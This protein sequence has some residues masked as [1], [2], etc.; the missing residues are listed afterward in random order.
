MPRR[1]PAPPADAPLLAWLLHILA[2][3]SRTRVKELLR[4]G[5]VAVNGV[6]VTRH[7]HPV[8]PADTLTLLDAAL[9]DTLGPAGV[10]VMY[11]DD[12]VIVV[13]KPAGLLTVATDAEKA[14][15]LFA[16][17]ADHLAAR[18]AGQPFVVHRL[19]RDT[20]GLVLF[21]RTPAARDT[22]QAGWN[23]VTKVYLAVVDGAPP[24][25]AGEV[26]NHLLEGKDLRVRAVPPGVPGAKRAVSTYRT[27][28]TGGQFGLVEV[29]LGTGRKHQIRVHLA[30]L[31]CPVVGDR[32]YGPR[33]EPRAAPAGRLGLHA[34][35]LRFP[36]P[37]GRQV[38][39]CESPL[40][41]D[42]RRLVP[43]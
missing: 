25:A 5:R 7:D 6:A 11:E 43:A 29:T 19:D 9:P 35:R 15:T 24:A 34:W 10:R 40:P 18:R 32:V 3:T 21:A 8:W 26:D 36:H 42:L 14:D 1:L 20:S 12:A 33:A 13:D 23:A 30:G 31:G 22:L 39:A 4:A 28:K 27:V 16:R 37:A 2:P 17:L 41:A 38:V